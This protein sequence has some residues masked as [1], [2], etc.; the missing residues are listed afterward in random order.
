MHLSNTSQLPS[1]GRSVI[2]CYSAKKTNPQILAENHHFCRVH[3]QNADFA[4]LTGVDINTPKAY[5]PSRHFFRRRPRCSNRCA[6]AQPE[7]TGT[8]LTSRKS[9]ESRRKVHTIR[10]PRWRSYPS[11][12]RSL[13]RWPWS[14]RSALCVTEAHG[15]EWVAHPGPHTCSIRC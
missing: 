5:L 2:P 15:A 9:E 12:E 14:V 4:L 6:T 10:A 1:T 8:F 3:E 7:A 11:T 13:L